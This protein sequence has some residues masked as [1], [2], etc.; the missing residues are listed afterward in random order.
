MPCPHTPIRFTHSRSNQNQRAQPY[1]PLWSDYVSLVAMTAEEHVPKRRTP[2][3]GGSLCRPIVGP[4]ELLDG[5]SFASGVRPMPH[6]GL[7]R[8]SCAVR[9]A[10]RVSAFRI[11]R[12]SS[13]RQTDGRIHFRQTTGSTLSRA[14]CAVTATVILTG[15]SIYSIGTLCVSRNAMAI[16]FPMTKL[17]S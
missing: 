16:S 8:D 5:R 2:K 6:I 11:A 9:R 4:T 17:T 13:F 7:A 15:S 3:R 12:R 14:C 10:N 1:A